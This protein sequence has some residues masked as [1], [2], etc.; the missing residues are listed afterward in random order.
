MVYLTST[1][2]A[3]STANLFI[4]TSNIV[5]VGQ[6]LAI[7]SQTIPAI[8]SSG[9]FGSGSPLIYTTG[10]STGK[11]G[12]VHSVTGGIYGTAN[13]CINTD[14]TNANI[15]LRNTSYTGTPYIDFSASPL[16]PDFT[17]RIILNSNVLGFQSNTYSFSAAGGGTGNVGIGTTSP[18]N[19]FVVQTSANSYGGDSL[20][21]AY[22]TGLGTGGGVRLMNYYTVSSTE[23]AAL[24]IY[25]ITT[26]TGAIGFFTNNGS[27]Q[28]ERMRVLANGNVGI[29]TAS[30][31]VSFQ[32][33]SSTS[34]YNNSTTSAKVNII[35]P[36]C[37]PSTSTGQALVST[38]Y[39]STEASQANNKGA[40]IGLGALQGFSSTNAMQ[41]RISGVP[42]N[43]AGIS[44]D[45]VFEVL[46]G[47]TGLLYEI[48][49]INGGS[50][51]V[52]IG[53]SSPSQKLHIS[54]GDPHTLYGPSASYN[55][56]LAVGSGNPPNSSTTA[57]VTC[58]NGNLH[59]DSAAFGAA[60]RGLYLNFFTSAQTAAGNGS[61]ILSYGPWTHTGSFTATGAKNF[62][63]PHPTVPNKD[64]VHSCIEGPR[65]DLMYRG[66]V[67][68]MN[69]TATVNMNKNS[70][71]TPDCAMTDGTFEALCTNPQFFLQNM[72]GFDRIRGTMSGANL[73][74]ISENQESADVISWMV[75]A[76]RHDADIISTEL[77]NDAGYLIT[78]H[79]S[80]PPNPYPTTPPS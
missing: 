13:V 17:A 57:T 18:L 75:V 61:G 29:G 47:N 68:L 3:A 72:S 63:I 34:D 8:S 79:D 62:R 56:N 53:T 78:E 6:N 41:A 59:I 71:T 40:S 65:V 20:Q 19:Q 80:L 60:G 38:L 74:I 35:G 5:S 10:T 67:T 31:K 36:S 45:L 50:G 26:T 55:M 42:N 37:T 14:G 43:S 25:S 15:E 64:L 30:P 54:G 23:L 12:V 77:T 70:T 33:G 24:K 52:G 4:S 9:A 21:V 46:F 11:H 22:D 27:G 51:N 66:T 32:V 39:V 48:M 1:G 16:A 49:R 58:S 28:T 44:G 2:V 69:G 73:V 7:G 76:E